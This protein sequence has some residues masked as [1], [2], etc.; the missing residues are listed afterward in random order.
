MRKIKFVSLFLLVAL[1]L[2]VVPVALAQGPDDN[3]L[4]P[5]ID[6]DVPQTV[7]R[8]V[9]GGVGDAMCDSMW[10]HGYTD[11]SWSGTYCQHYSRSRDEPNHWYPCDIDKIGVRGRLWVNDILMDE[12][13]MKYNYDSADKNGSTRA[14]SASCERDFE[15]ARSNHY[16]QKAG[17]PTWQP[18]SSDSC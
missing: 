15:Y 8:V 3:K 16:F 1:L 13:P 4:P 18:E 14:A 2:S 6:K 9:G 12:D 17:L 11:I 7:E 5:G 10:W